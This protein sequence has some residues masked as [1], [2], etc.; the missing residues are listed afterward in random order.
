MMAIPLS[1]PHR[2][3]P[4][5]GRSALIEKLERRQLLSSAYHLTFDDEF[6]S[7]NLATYNTSGQALTSGY[8]S[9][10]Q[11][12]YAAYDPSDDSFEYRA[13]PA[14]DPY[15][16]FSINNGILSISAELTP[17]NMQGTGAGQTQANYVTG[18]LTTAQGGQPFNTSNG[19]SQEYG[20]FE[21]RCE[22]P[23]G[24]GLWPA[25]WLLPEP[26]LNTS[27]T[28]V[29]YDSFEIP[30]N[31]DSTQDQNTQT[32]YQTWHANDTSH[33]TSYTLPNG[34]DSSTSYHT[35]GF[36]WDAN[37]IR[38]YVDGQLTRT[39]AN[40]SN[41]P[42]YMLMTLDV[43]GS[44]PGQPNS[45]TPFPASFKIDYVRAY[46]NNQNIP[47]VTPQTGYS[48]SADTLDAISLGTGSA[49]GGAQL[50]GTPS[51]SS[52][53]SYDNDG[54]TYLNVF[55]GN[56]GSF[57]DAPSANGNWVQ[58]D[59]G[60]AQPLGQIAFAPRVGFENRM[61]GGIVEASN[62]P[63]FTTGV[64]TL[65]TVTSTP[66]D[67]LTDVPVSGT[68]R[69]IRYV[70]PAGSYGNIAEMQV[71]A[72]GSQT[73]TTTQLTGTASANTTSSYDGKT[74]DNFTAVFDGNTNTFFDAPAA[75]GNYVQLDL[76]AADSIAQIA[77]A[78]RVG[79]EYRMV[80]G[81]FEASNDPT[82]TTGVVT[83]YTLTATPSDGLTTENVNAGGSYR[84]IRYVSPSGSYGNIAEMQVFGSTGTTPA[85]AQ[86]TG[87]SSANTTSSYD[88]QT[89]D[90]FT[91][92]FDG[93]TS[94]YVDAPTANGNWVQLNLGA[95]HTLKQIAFAPRAGF[96][97]RM[98][99][100]YFEASNDPT[101]TTGVTVLY[102]ITAAPSDGLTTVPVTASGTFQ[103][104]RY[105]SP[106]GSYGNI[107]EMQLFGY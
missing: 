71:F 100:G 29:E 76:G 102:T 24:A 94:T 42:M 53:S 44:W 32:I 1:R 56:I 47:A 26:N 15:N 13:N 69:Y 5:A 39:V 10:D 64:A 12:D 57:W 8:L 19:F 104:V 55:D 36:E 35:Y 95:Q 6:N 107:A 72:P 62:D 46:S 50:T 105:V 101:F 86:L 79:F 67:G 9:R 17:A 84:Y 28:Q 33:T 45:S 21:M 61:V 14:T 92:A 27:N 82:F 40:V 70:A 58:L 80:G 11:N 75:N 93:N 87:T 103:Y 59:L 34:G 48:A 90:S 66:T 4:R 51:A 77:F 88:G 65:D 23:A 18:E 38:W 20:Y 98:V 2:S 81:I 22:V 97:Y 78:P 7:L 54:D 41:T 99:G 106:A 16:P 37:S 30:Q 52:T 31:S 73:V 63:T 83:L 25:F 43:G 85:T 49:T 74:S 60:S 3:Y 89:S 68:Y 91:A 96:E